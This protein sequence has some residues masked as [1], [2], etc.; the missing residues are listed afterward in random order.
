MRPMLRVPGKAIRFALIL[1][2]ERGYPTDEMT[3]AF[4][5]LGATSRRGSV[6]EWLR[7]LGPKKLSELIDDRLKPM[8]RASLR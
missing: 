6:E 3:D 7:S 8:S 4:R 5:E 1:L 2:K